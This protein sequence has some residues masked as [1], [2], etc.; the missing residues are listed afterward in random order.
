[1]VRI[2]VVRRLLWTV[3][4]AA[5]LYL[6]YR[7]MRETL[8]PRTLDVSERSSGPT[9]SAWKNV[10]LGVGL[11]LSSP[12]AVLWF[13]ATAGAIVAEANAADRWGIAAF[14]AG[15]FAAGV[16]WAAALAT[17]S[18]KTGRQIGSGWVRVMS[19]ASAALFLYFAVRIA[20]G[21]VREWLGN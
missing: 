15:F 13:A 2:D 18:G 14:V 21:G 7:M 16:L 17:V 12:T 19:A 11:A 3:G 4:T 9:R 5:L 10:L 8:A 6:A 20:A 1:M